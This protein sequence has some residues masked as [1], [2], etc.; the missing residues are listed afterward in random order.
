MAD[1]STP[2]SGIEGIVLKDP[3]Y[4]PRAYEFVFEALAHTLSRLGKSGSRDPEMGIASGQHVSGRELLDGVRDLALEQFGL[5]ARIVFHQWGIQRTD[6]FGEMVFNLVEAGL[7]SAT[8]QDRREDFC[9]AYDFEEAL[10]RAYEI[11][12]D[13]AL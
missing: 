5:M 4:D 12:M 7:M 6:D 3:R 11:R 9:G 13:E 2:Y 10:V 1:M 8:P